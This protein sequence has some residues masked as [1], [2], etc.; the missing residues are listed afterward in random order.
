MEE[1][2]HI[3]DIH[4]KLKDD[5]LHFLN[6]IASRWQQNISTHN[7]T[8]ISRD[9][10]DRVIPSI[11]Q[12]TQ[13]ILSGSGGSGWSN[14]ITLYFVLKSFGINVK[15]A[16]CAVSVDH[17]FENLIGDHVVILVSDV[18][19]TVDTY[20]MDVGCG[21]PCFRIIPTDFK[22]SSVTYKDS[23]IK[24]RYVKESSSIIK[25]EHCIDI[26]NCDP[27]DLD[28]TGDSD[29]W[30]TYYYIWMKEETVDF[31]QNQIDYYVYRDLSSDFNNHLSVVKYPNG[32]LVAL[33]NKVLIWENED[34]DVEIMKIN[35]SDELVEN[36][37]HYFPEIAE[38]FIT[39]ALYNCRDLA[40]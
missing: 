26:G 31:I 37:V 20:I 14:N 34:G 40:L 27:C 39:N 10:L 22:H 32:R 11:E 3:T 8:Q 28:M 6:E 16:L 15:L 2:L 12:C 36:L 4:N 23:L 30:K 17:T 19:A 1:K 18:S 7:V 13:N 33:K 25:R 21:Y 24:Y 9:P 29:I 35:T 38:K 5:K